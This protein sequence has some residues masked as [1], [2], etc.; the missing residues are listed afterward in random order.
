MEKHRLANGAIT[1]WRE[2]D[3]TILH[4]ANGLTLAMTPQEADELLFW[5]T[6]GQK[7]RRLNEDKVQLVLEWGQAQEL[8]QGLR[9]HFPG[10]GTLPA[11]SPLEAA[12]RVFRGMLGRAMT[13]DEEE[14]GESEQ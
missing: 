4:H 3:K 2:G 8:L 1:T 10:D 7:E 9:E 13:A 5:L 6:R 14:Q 12:V 11:R